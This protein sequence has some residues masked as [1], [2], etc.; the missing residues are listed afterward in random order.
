M[1]IFKIIAP[2]NKRPS[3]GPFV[4]F[5][6]FYP[7]PVKLKCNEI[8]QNWSMTIQALKSN[9]ELRFGILKKPLFSLFDVIIFWFNGKIKQNI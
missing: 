5:S 9:Q 6:S 7:L 1:E 4:I 2:S 8:Q 3:L